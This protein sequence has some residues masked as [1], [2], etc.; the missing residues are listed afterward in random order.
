MTLNAQISASVDA[1]SE[2]VHG[3]TRSITCNS[4]SFDFNSGDCDKVWSDV[5]TFPAG[6]YVDIDMSAI[7]IGTVKLICLKNR[8]TSS[9]I[10][11]TAGLSG[12]QFSNFLVDTQAWNFMPMINLGSLTLRGYPIRQGG[13]M[14]LAC[15]DSTGFATTVG[16]SIM[17]LG[18][19]AGEAYEIYIM[20]NQ[21]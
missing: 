13:A 8:S 9:S 10:G 14:L 17:R 21:A 11:M 7:G 3:L 2:G 19:V 15:P 12:S 5:N 4:V 20:G 1:L 16:G 18:G 6:G